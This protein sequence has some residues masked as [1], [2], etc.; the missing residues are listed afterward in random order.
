[1]CCQI[2]YLIFGK[3]PYSWCGITPLV[4]TMVD[5][6]RELPP[7]WESKW[8]QMKADATARGEPG[9]GTWKPSSDSRLEK[10]FDKHVHDAQLKA[11]LP[12]IQG[13][14]KLLPSD[15]ISASD[16]LKVIRDSGG[17]IDPSE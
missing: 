12:V 14:T 2:Y 15:R 9:V 16:A 13:L 5:V 10:Q 4:H 1:M 7:E 17:G 6:F 11:L 3:L 8:E